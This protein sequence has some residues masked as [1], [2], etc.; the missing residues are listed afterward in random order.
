MI[1][2]YMVYIF[3]AIC[4]GISI[5]SCSSNEVQPIPAI[6]DK[7]MLTTDAMAD[8]IGEVYGYLNGYDNRKAMA[9]EL[10]AK[11]MNNYER[12]VALA[13]DGSVHS[14]AYTA[15]VKLALDMLRWIQMEEQK[16][17]SVNRHLIVEQFTSTLCADTVTPTQIDS[18][19][20]VYNELF[21]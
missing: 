4:F 19:R 20:S 14:E 6:I 9:A 5:D 13:V 8:S 11:Y 1:M 10:D 7:E 12:G 3:V 18:V 2:K 21:K 15:G 17:V 16:G